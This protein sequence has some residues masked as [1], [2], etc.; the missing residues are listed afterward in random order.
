MKTVAWLKD[1]LKPARKRKPIDPMAE[2]TFLAG[3]RQKHTV[4]L[5]MRLKTE[6]NTGGHWRG[7]AARAKQQRQTACAAL[8][9]VLRVAKWQPPLTIIITRYGLALLDSDNLPSSAKHVRD[10]IADAFGTDDGHESGLT[11]EY[12]QERATCFAVGIDIERETKAGA[13]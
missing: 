5:P 10:G 6:S 12:R 4:A 2:Q 13:K 11:W 1:G 7:K 8:F 9:H 3:L